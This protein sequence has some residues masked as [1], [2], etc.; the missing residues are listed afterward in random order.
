M[1]GA[2]AED[3]LTAKNEGTRLLAKDS[4]GLGHIL[5]QVLLGIPQGTPSMAGGHPLSLSL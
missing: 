2:T 5:G 4:H 1:E 3:S